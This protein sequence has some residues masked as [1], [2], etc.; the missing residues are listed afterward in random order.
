MAEEA[1]NRGGAGAAGNDGFP[2]YRKTSDN[3]HFYRI[4]GLDR[5]T[6][7]Q[8]MGSRSI[9]HQVRATQYPERLRIMDMI[10]G[11]DGRYLPMDEREWPNRSTD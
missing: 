4:E 5:F 8:V 7:I 1:Q 3:K 2:L 10:E 11:G 6:E 9:E